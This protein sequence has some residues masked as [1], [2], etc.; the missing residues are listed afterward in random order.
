ANNCSSYTQAHTHTHTHILLYSHIHKCTHK[1]TYSMHTYTHKRTQLYSLSVSLVHTQTHT[2][3]LILSF[4]AD[5]V[6]SHPPLKSC[7]DIEA[8]H[9]SGRFKAELPPSR[10]VLSRVV[11]HRLVS[12]PR[13]LSAAC[14]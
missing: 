5:C 3:F 1:L 9:C 12:S 10:L 6:I 13:A 14:E 7:F 11:S 4:T 8:P 2:F